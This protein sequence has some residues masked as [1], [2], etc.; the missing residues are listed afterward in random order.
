MNRRLIQSQQC[1]YYV[2]RPFKQETPFS[3]SNTYWPM[4]QKCQACCKQVLSISHA[5][6][7]VRLKNKLFFEGSQ[8]LDS[9]FLSVSY[10]LYRQQQSGCS[11]QNLNYH[12]KIPTI[13]RNR[14]DFLS[15]LAATV[16]CHLLNYYMY[17]NVFDTV[18][19]MH[20]LC[21]I[22]HMHPSTPSTDNSTYWMNS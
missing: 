14:W 3:K 4:F 15:H 11:L 19:Q 16:C 1:H 17:N 8:L 18:H 7:T 2:D 21:I 20:F 22:K 13:D 5:L 12:F 6:E 9:L 10:R